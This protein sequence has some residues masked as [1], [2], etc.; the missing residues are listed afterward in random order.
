ML[1]NIEKNEATVDKKMVSFLTHTLTNSLG[2]VPSTLRDII[3]RLSPEYEQK[4]K[5]IN[6][7]A[8]LVTTFSI[9]NTLV[10][11]FKLYIADHSRFESSWHQDNQGES[12]IELVLALALRETVNNILF[13][14]ASRVKKLLPSGTELNIKALRESFMNEM[15]VLELDS[16]N[17]EQVFRWLTQNLNI[18]SFEL[19]KNSAIHFKKNGIRF[20]FLFSILSEIIYNALKYST[21]KIELTW[22]MVQESYE[23]TCCNTFDP[24]IRHEGNSTQQGLVFVEALIN[25]LKKSTL[26]YS[27]ENDLFTVKLSFHKTNFVN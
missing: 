24:E 12:S 1:I 2:T 19:E 17:A 20:T 3:E 26:S 5:L 22:K 23:F 10:K 7:L 15:M 13:S 6:E 4:T 18:F 16:H 8:S 9:V 25:R 14:P 27:E 21:G 11:T